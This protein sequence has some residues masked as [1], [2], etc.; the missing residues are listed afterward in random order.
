M[1]S[2]EQAMVAIEFHF[3]HCT[4]HVGPRGGVKTNIEVWRANGRCKTWKTRPNDFA[5]PIKRGLRSHTYIT[6]GNAEYYHTAFD[7]P[8]K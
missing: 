2:K 1:V 7:C 3:N 4:K 5:I 6:N 8:V